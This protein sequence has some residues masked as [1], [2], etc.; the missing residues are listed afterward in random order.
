MS[1]TFGFV[2][3]CERFIFFMLLMPLSHL[4]VFVSQ[5]ISRNTFYWYSGV[6]T[7]ACSILQN[8]GILFCKLKFLNDKQQESQIINVLLVHFLKPVFVFPSPAFLPWNFT[9]VIIIIACVKFHICVKCLCFYAV[10]SLSLWL[11][12][13]QNG[14]FAP[15]N[16]FNSRGSRWENA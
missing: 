2:L 6:Q 7:R 3:L 8:S 1:K 13:L 9:L 11:V 10:R 12:P 16:T 4:Y 15:Y 5:P 14:C